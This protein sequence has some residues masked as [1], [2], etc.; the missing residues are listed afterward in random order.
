MRTLLDTCILSELRRS[1]CDQRVKLAIAELAN[2]ELFVSMISMGEIIKG[3]ALLDTGIRKQ[4]LLRWVR[5]LEQNYADR[6]LPVDLEVVRIWGE[7]TAMAQK[8]G[9]TIPVCDG[10]IASTARR[11]GLHLM[12]RNTDDFEPT[13][14][15]L[16]NPWQE[17]S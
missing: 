12:T 8:Q 3:I 1:A 11:H 6:L 4:E 16:I 15:I 5:N 17:N 7:I 2:E 9:F 13:G 14:V 10:L